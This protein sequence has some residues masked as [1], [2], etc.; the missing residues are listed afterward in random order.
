MRRTPGRAPREAAPR[1]KCR[2]PW[3]RREFPGR[4]G[5]KRPPPSSR[6][7][8][9]NPIPL[10]GEQN[11]RRAT[12]GRGSRAPRE[13]R[14][15]REAPLFPRP[16]AAGRRGAAGAAR[17]RGPAALPPG[18]PGA[19]RSRPA[20]RSG[21]QRSA[22]G[23]IPGR[24]RSAR[25]ANP[26]VVPARLG[27]A[28]P[29]PLEARR[30]AGA[31][32]AS[33]GGWEH[34]ARLRCRDPRSGPRGSAPPGWWPP[35]TGGGGRGEGSR[36]EAGAPSPFGL[37]LP[38]Q[39]LLPNEPRNGDVQPSPSPSHTRRGQ[40][41]GKG[42]GGRSREAGAG[43]EAPERRELTHLQ[44]GSPSRLWTSGS[45][46][47]Y[48]SEFALALNTSPLNKSLEKKQPLFPPPPHPPR[49]LPAF[50]NIQLKMK[51]LAEAG[52]EGEVVSEVI[53]GGKM[54]KSLEM[55]PDRHPPV[56]SLAESSSRRC[57][58]RSS[59]ALADWLRHCISPAWILI[60]TT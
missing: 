28:R 25:C 21:A 20:R 6:L 15:A 12:P 29:R 10:P 26:R 56:P 43:S 36:E 32:R 48:P 8:K 34:R 60:W 11:G 14:E 23:S 59:Q 33:S 22:A 2:V 3:Q 13:A 5:R 37:P 35:Q 1:N 42:G 52:A 38:L 58:S 18:G 50:V 40:K 16:R 27:S 51:P 17:R 41:T 9:Q 44:T 31:L 19:Q 54:E 47:R 7:R 30:R 55:T 45:R 39:Q 49:T 46:R 24:R 4:G 57:N 53:P